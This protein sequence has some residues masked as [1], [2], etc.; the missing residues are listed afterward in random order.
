MALIR[1]DAALLAGGHDSR[2]VLQVH[3]EV[4]LEV[5]DDEHEAVGQLTLDVMHGAADL[6]VPLEVNLAFGP[7]WAAA[8]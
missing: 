5:P 4:I 3:D 2:I 1:L 6:R 8:K 7:S